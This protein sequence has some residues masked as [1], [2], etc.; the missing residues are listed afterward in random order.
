M[1]YEFRILCKNDVICDS[2]I[3]IMKQMEFRNVR[4]ERRA[5]SDHAGFKNFN[6]ISGARREA[7]KIRSMHDVIG[8]RIIERD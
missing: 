6:T 7:E 3:N 5:G 8:V 2:I 1:K 4:K